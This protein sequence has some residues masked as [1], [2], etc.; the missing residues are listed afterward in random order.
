MRSVDGK[1]TG[2]GVVDCVSDYLGIVHYLAQV[3]VDGVATDD[4]RLTH[5]E[6]LGVF[7]A[8]NRSLVLAAVHHH[9]GSVL[10]G[11]RW[12]VTLDL[13]VSGQQTDLCAHGE[14]PVAVGLHRGV[15]A[16]LEGGCEGNRHRIRGDCGDCHKLTLVVELVRWGNDDLLASLPVDGH[17]KM[18]NCIACLCGLTEHSPY[19]GP[20]DTVDVDRRFVDR[21]SLVSEHRQLGVAYVAPHCDD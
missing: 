12:R 1:H 3:E 9:V 21:Y 16:V 5:V 11:L 7:D 8:G 19:G 10:S 17:Q 15:V 13:D 20:G 18:Q 4:H 14:R 2:E 6:E